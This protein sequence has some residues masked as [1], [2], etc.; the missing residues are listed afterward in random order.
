MYASST[1]N[2]AGTVFS[3]VTGSVLGT[4][5]TL[6]KIANNQLYVEKGIVFGG[7]AAAAGLV[8]RGI[9][10]IGTPE[11]NGTCSKENLY[12]NYDGVNTFN[13]SRQVVLQAGTI[14]EDYGNNVYQYCAVRGDALK[15]YSDAHYAAKSHTSAVASASSL[16][17]IKLGSDT[18]QTV[19]P[20]EVSST[21]GK[22]YAVQLNSS[23]QAV[24]NVPWSNTTYSA[25]T[26]LSL[27]GTTF[28]L[29]TAATSSIGG[30]KLY[31]DTKQTVA[32]NK[33]SS[34]AGKTYA[35]QLNSSN[36]AVVNVPWSDTD[37][38]NT[39]GATET[40]SK[41]YLIGAIDQLAN[42]Q[43]YSNSGIY[44]TNGVLT[45]S[46]TRIGGGNVTLEYNTEDECLD[47]V[48]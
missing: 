25:G 47:F 32:P 30:I 22:T 29:K 19:A 8:T 5:K 11:S 16:G 9:C 18:K 45:T 33:V 36:Q 28:S 48:F 31:S 34:T 2:L 42:P 20:N 23:N 41:I 46:K 27:S 3:H 14:G 4:S 44:G 37:T 24:V 7:T 21:A 40:T 43:T 38:K 26:G 6:T 12:I 39:A 13:A 35:V 15:N 1:I 10:G 17:H